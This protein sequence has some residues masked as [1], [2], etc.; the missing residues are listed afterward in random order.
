MYAVTLEILG[1]KNQPVFESMTGYE[2]LSRLSRYNLS[3][4]SPKE[5]QAKSVLGKPILIKINLSGQPE[6]LIHAYITAFRRSA[7]DGT[8][9]SVRYHLEAYCWLWFLTRSSDCRVFQKKRVIDI[10]KEII[11]EPQYQGFLIEDKTKSSNTMWEYAVQYR[12]TDFN[13]IC[14][15]LEQEGIY[16]YFEHHKSGHKMVLCDDSS[17]S[18]NKEQLSYLA[19]PNLPAHKII[20][21]WSTE[22]TIQPSQYVLADYNPLEKAQQFWAVHHAGKY[23][24]ERPDS[25]IYDYP[26]EFDSQKEGQQYAKIRAEELHT[27]YCVYTGASNNLEITAGSCFSLS[28]LHW[29]NP[30]EGFLITAVTFQL[31]ENS[32]ESGGDYVTSFSNSFKAIPSKIMF[33]PA[34]TTPKPCIQGLQSAM[35]TGPKGSEIYSNNHLQVKVK[36]HWDRHANAKPEESSCWIRVAQPWAGKNRGFFAIPRVGDEVI[37]A[38][39]E[40]DPDRPLIIGSVYNDISRSKHTIETNETRTGLVTLS[41]KQGADNFNEL[42]FEDKKGN[43]LV[44]LRAEKDLKQLVNND[45][46]TQVNHNVTITVNNNVTE[47]IKNNHSVKIGNNDTVKVANN[48]VVDVGQAESLKAG[49][50]ITV[51]AG[52]SITIEAGATITLKAGPST[53]ELGPSGITIKGPIVKIN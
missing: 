35:V 2:E 50:N 31:T 27:G 43:E 26:G 33:R 37:V 52:Q 21:A 5:I 6:R 42:S 3:V 28:A 48:R 17:A 47:E 15:L 4:L 14:R 34:R 51:K 9:T 38:F 49:T 32:Y 40:G 8:H 20:T 44:Y 39:E 30:H 18:P 11:N 36:F 46:I 24:I 29:K 41:S 13:F 45:V 1:L 12:E 53:I 19:N 7:S 10:F 16:F 25:E 23:E 22:K